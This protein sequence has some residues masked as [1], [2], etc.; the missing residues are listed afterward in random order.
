MYESNIGDV[1]KRASTS[2]SSD[3]TATVKEQI[4]MLLADT[5]HDEVKL[6][7]WNRLC[8]TIRAYRITLEPELWF[9]ILDDDV[10]G[11]SFEDRDEKRLTLYTSLERP[12]IK[13]CPITF[14]PYQYVLGAGW[15]LF[16]DITQEDEKPLTDSYD[17]AMSVVESTD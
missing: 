1:M 8:E 3:P 4:R 7:T 11:S 2:T 5:G 9:D 6:K 13:V 12:L 16:S 14:Q 10:I 17:N 15:V